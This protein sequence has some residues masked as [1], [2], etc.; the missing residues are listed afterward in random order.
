MDTK[1]TLKLDFNTIESAKKYARQKKTSLSVLVE[2]YF[3]SLTKRKKKKYLSDELLGC[4]KDLKEYS[5][6]ELKDQ[7]IKD[8]Y[9]V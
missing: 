4:M 6:E 1:L 5:L 2:Q 3:K 7:Y 8:K 9:G